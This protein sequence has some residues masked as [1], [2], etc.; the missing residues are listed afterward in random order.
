MNKE[1]QKDTHTETPKFDVTHHIL[2]LAQDINT[3]KWL[4]DHGLAETLLY[5]REALLD[6]R[7]YARVDKVSQSGL[8][9]I[10]KMAYISNNHLYH[11]SNTDILKLAGCNK[12]GRINGCGMDML[13]AAQYN[14]F[15]ALCPELRYQDF[16]PNY[17]S[18]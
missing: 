18:L 6:K 14:I 9:R 2:S 16:M 3:C 8:S 10:I 7:F 15:V 17:G 11:V 13:F 1:T 4:S 12:Q 5:I